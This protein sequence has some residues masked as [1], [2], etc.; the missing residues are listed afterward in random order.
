MVQ[1]FQDFSTYLESS[2][3][4]SLTVKNY[5]ADLRHFEKWFLET[6][7]FTIILQDKI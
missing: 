4:S 3:R 1:I 5:L 2:E 7:A 6:N